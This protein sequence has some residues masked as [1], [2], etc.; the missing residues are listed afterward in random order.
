MLDFFLIIFLSLNILKPGGAI[1]PVV[2]LA[3]NW[4]NIIQRD[5]VTLMCNV[6]PTAPEEPRTYQ[7]YKDKRPLDGDQQTLEIQSSAIMD[8]GDY[9]CQISAGDISDPITLNVTNTYLILQRPPSA[10]YEGDPLTLRCHHNKE[11]VGFKAHFYKDNKEIKSQFPDSEFH[12]DKVDLNTTGRY[13]CTKLITSPGNPG[14]TE[15]SDEFSV[16][17]K[18]LFSSPKM[19]VTP[20]MVL[21]GGDMTVTC[22]TRPDPLRGGTKLQFSFFRNG[23]TVRGFSESDTYRVKS[24]QQE[25]SGEYTCEVRTKSGT[26]RKISDGFNVQIE[27]IT[28]FITT[29]TLAI[30]GGLLLIVLSAVIIWRC[31]KRK[32]YAASNQQPVPETMGTKENPDPH[33]VCY[34]YLELSHFPKGNKLQVSH[35]EESV[36][37]ATVKNTNI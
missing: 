21:E 3:P 1:R 2:S 26:V 19:K 13:K 28:F 23:Q 24:A 8:T 9:Q 11:F 5:T 4:G 36:T 32:E 10:I 30:V 33:D 34:T 18:E 12:V 6:P 14:Y 7:W 20:H 25:D 15:F 27:S 22:D 29:L 16:S 31:K 17:V 35:D 37:Y